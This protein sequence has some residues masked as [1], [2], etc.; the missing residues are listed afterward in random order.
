MNQ[1]NYRVPPE[2]PDSAESRALR[3]LKK[4][5]YHNIQQLDWVAQDA[6]GQWV[7]VEIKDKELFEPGTNYPQWGAGLD[8][9]QLYLRTQLLENLGWSTKF[10]HFEKGTST[11]YE[12][13]LED[14]ESSGDYYD[15]PNDI[16]I[17]PI[18]HFTR[19]EYK[20]D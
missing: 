8:K 18:E 7:V 15:T 9:S 11:Y 6:E 1:D 2:E 4:D 16:R 5:G 3:M 19:K 13:L 20:E 10:I 17:Y 12:A 14:L